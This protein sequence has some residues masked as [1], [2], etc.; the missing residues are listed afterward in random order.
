MHNPLETYFKYLTLFLFFRDLKPYLTKFE[1][2]RIGALKEVQVVVC[3]MKCIDLCIEAIKILG[4]N[5]SY[6]SR[7]KEECNFLKIVSIV[8]N[9]LNLWQYR[10]VTLEG[11]IVAFESLA[12]SKIIFQALI[13]PVPT[14]VIKALETIQTCFLWNNSNP[15]T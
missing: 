4:I 12:I 14:H 7:I 1:I 6:N 2:A 3:S 10:N 9:V 5:F 13:T 8:Q 11:R 15:K